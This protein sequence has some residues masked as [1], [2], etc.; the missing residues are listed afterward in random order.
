MIYFLI[1]T[2]HLLLG[3]AKMVLDN[4]DE[5]IATKLEKPLLPDAKGPTPIHDRVYAMLNAKFKIKREKYF[6]QTLVG[7]DAHRMLRH[8]NS[9]CDAIRNI[10]L[11][12]VDRRDID[13]GTDIDA[14]IATF[15]LGIKDVLRVFGV[16]YSWMSQ[17]KQLSLEE[18]VD[19]GKLCKEFG[20]IW[21]HTYPGTSITPKLHLIEVHA[22]IQ[23]SMFGCLGDKI[24]SAV[25]RIHNT[26]N[27]S[28]R[29]LASVRKYEDRTRLMLSRRAVGASPEVQSVINAVQ[30]SA[31]RKFKP[32]KA[33]ARAN[34]VA[35]KVAIKR[36]NVELAKATGN[37][38]FDLV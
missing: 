16:L 13:P 32:T 18:I 17:T 33:A 20:K 12:H 26:C 36:Q 23:M 8:H 30:A 27:K 11:E 38:F 1:P 7:D 22:P 15:M 28:G 31:K 4:M 34:K 9:V 37:L 21:R 5:F 14:E 35:V 3:I 6:T 24:E 19:F 25:E 2:L 10:L 29:V